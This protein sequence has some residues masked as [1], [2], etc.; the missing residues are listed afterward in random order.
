MVI[1]AAQRANADE[2]ISELPKQY[3]TL[4]GERGV[5]LSGGQRQRISIARA[6]L[7]N[8][9]I[10]ILDE[11]TSSLD[12]ESEQKIQR[13]IKELFKCRTTFVIAHRLSTIASADLIIVLEKGRMVESGSHDQL[14]GQ[15]GLY[16]DMVQRQRQ[17]L[18]I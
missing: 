18:L 3:D 1:D 9:E 10:L 6:F 11:A 16:F 4:I 5:K 2:F 15:R 13:A 12:T 14:L 8:P 17:S 7:A